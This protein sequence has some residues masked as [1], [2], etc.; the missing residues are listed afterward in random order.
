[1]VEPSLV[2]VLD[3]DVL[4]FIVPDELVP[5]EELVVVPVDEPVLVVLCPLTRL[6][7]SRQ[8]ASSVMCVFI[9]FLFSLGC[10]K[11]GVTTL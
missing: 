9:V 5:V 2:D 3:G 7:P 6:A 11:K 10:I 8:N 1:M 4:L